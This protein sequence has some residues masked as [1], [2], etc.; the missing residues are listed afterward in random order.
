MYVLTCSA[1]LYK[2]SG[3]TIRCTVWLSTVLFKKSFNLAL[4]LA[5]LVYFN[6]TFTGLAQ[7]I[8]YQNV[9]AC[10]T[11][12]KNIVKE[13]NLLTVLL[14]MLQTILKF[15]SLKKIK[16]LAFP[17]NFNIFIYNLYKVELLKHVH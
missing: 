4:Y 2:Q 8:H 5:I 15:I 17:R 1:S 3:H 9:V 11:S 10:R 12:K 14:K 16:M 6:S 7:E 13:W